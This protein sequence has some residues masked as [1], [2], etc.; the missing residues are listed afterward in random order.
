MSQ[1]TEKTFDDAVARFFEPIAREHGWPLIHII[2]EM[3][4]VSTS[5]FI[6]RIHFDV[7]AHRKSI[8]ASFLPKEDMLKK[9]E[10]ERRELGVLVIAGYNGVPIEFIPWD[11]TE[12][13]FFAQAQYMAD[14]VKEFGLP[15]L[16]GQKSD[17]DEVEEDLRKEKEK[18]SYKAKGYIF[19]SRVQKRWHLPDKPE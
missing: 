3:Y 4:E 16:L 18:T 15:Y 2:Q 8:Y 6:M 13:G 11:Q 7:G 1:I 10:H 12:S 14:M 17:W 9:S 5:Y 19:S